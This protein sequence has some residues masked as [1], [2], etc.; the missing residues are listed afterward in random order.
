M[1]ME[2][3]ESNDIIKNTIK[4]NIINNI[5]LLKSTDEFGSYKYFINIGEDS[6]IIFSFYSLDFDKL[7][8]Y[9][10]K[11]WISKEFSQ[12]E[13]KL[14]MEV[15]NFTYSISFFID[16]SKYSICHVKPS[17]NLSEEEKNAMLLKSEELKKEMEEFAE[18]VS[19]KFACFRTNLY[20]SA[21]KKSIDDINNKITPDPLVLRLN[22]TNKLYLISDT[23]KLLVVFGM[24]FEAKTDC[25]LAKLFFRELDDAK[26]GFN[27]S[28]DIKYFVNQVP[29]FL[30]K[31]D[32]D[33]N[34]N[35]GL[36]VF[37]KKIN[38]LFK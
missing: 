25:N 29:E 14:N 21:I 30:S 6:R 5:C 28:V 17:K 13:Y 23:E 9:S 1:R 35:S 38:I 16:V 3:G 37:S 11:D 33:L 20:A 19:N 15:A 10:G 24:H 2:I 12:F 7:F 18:D 27:G 31:V 26:I 4:N 8:N 36:V 22:N 32:K 34:Y